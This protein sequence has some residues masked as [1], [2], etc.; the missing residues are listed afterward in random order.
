MANEVLLS[1]EAIETIN[2]YMM[3]RVIKQKPSLTVPTDEKLSQVVDLTGA[4]DGKLMMMDAEKCGWFAVDTD[5][6]WKQ[7]ILNG[8]CLTDRI[9]NAACAVLKKQFS[10]HGGLELTLLQQSTRGLANAA[11]AMRTIHL[12]EKSHWTVILT[13]WC[14]RSSLKYYDSSFSSV[15]VEADSIIASLL[16]PYGSLDVQK[17]LLTVVF[18]ALPIALVWH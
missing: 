10:G 2:M 16:K 6:L 8:G 18:M 17:I 3:E 4:H 9:I 14:N 15:S 5:W 7:N 13:I 12:P 1:G 11:N